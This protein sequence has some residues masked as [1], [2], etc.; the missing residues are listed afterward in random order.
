MTFLRRM[1]SFTLF[2]Y[3]VLPALLLC[4]VIKKPAM[5]WIAL[6]AVL[7]WIGLIAF[8]GVFRIN[9]QRKR[10][11]M[12]RR[13]PVPPQAPVSDRQ[14]IAT[15]CRQTMITDGSCGMR[16]LKAWVLSTMITKDP[17]ESALSTVIASASADPENRADL[18][19]TCL[20]KQYMR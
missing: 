6:L 14:S 19:T 2:K 1:K 4:A 15:R 12:S 18:I 17:Y 10:K 11:S 7:L 20:E 16:E 3:L 9:Q 8:E 13:K 5:Q